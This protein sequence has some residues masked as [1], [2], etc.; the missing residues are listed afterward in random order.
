MSEDP[1]RARRG[2]REGYVPGYSAATVRLHQ[3][4]TL[5]SCAP[6]FLPYLERGIVFWTAAV[7]RAR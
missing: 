6:F 5:T 7:A 1:N 4:R 3:W 2:R